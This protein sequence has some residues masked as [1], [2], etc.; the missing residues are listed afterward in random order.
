MKKKGYDKISKD[1]QLPKSTVQSI[2]K[3]VKD[4]GNLENLSRSGRPAKVSTTGIRRIVR[5]V[6]KN[7]RVTRDEIRSILEDSGTSVSRSTVTNILHKA[8]LRGC[9]PRKAPLLRSMHLKARLKFADDYSAKETSY[10]N[11]VLWSDETKLELFSHSSS[12]YVWRKK[13]EA[14][15]AKNTIPTVKHGGGSLMFWGCFSAKSV[16]ALVCVNGI[17]KKEDYRDILEVNLKQSARN[18]GMGRRWIFQ[19][20]NDPKHTSKLVSKWL[21]DERINVLPWPSQSPDLN[22]I[23]NKWVELKKRLRQRQPSTL[24]ELEVITKEERRKISKETCQK[25][26]GDYSGRLTKVIENKGFTID[27]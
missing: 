11:S 26:L 24:A 6:Y 4:S 19:P 10:W 23:E 8:N 25:Y 3:N 7:P 1:L 17:V 18:L 5:E 21:A 22:P 13:N 2:I 9:R 12:Q 20:D 16:G 15:K 14:F 27:Y